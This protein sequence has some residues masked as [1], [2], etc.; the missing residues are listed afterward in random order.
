MRVAAKEHQPSAAAPRA[1]AKLDDV[2]TGKRLRM[3]EVK[4]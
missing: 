2:R 3:T 1:T 4:A